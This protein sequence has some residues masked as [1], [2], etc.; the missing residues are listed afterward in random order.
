MNKPLSIVI[1]IALCVAF[2]VLMKNDKGVATSCCQVSE[3][4][5]ASGVTVTKEACEEMDGIYSDG[6][7]CNTDTGRCE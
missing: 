7:E 2:F 4:A 5:C 3:K 1:V 6:Q